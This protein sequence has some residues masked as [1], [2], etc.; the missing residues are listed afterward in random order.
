MTGIYSNRN[1][2]YYGKDWKFDTAIKMR[3]ID[4][5]LLVPET[6]K[7]SSVTIPK[8]GRVNPIISFP[9]TI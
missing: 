7:E 8:G 2:F 4:L 3:E 5:G 6:L 1:R 9:E